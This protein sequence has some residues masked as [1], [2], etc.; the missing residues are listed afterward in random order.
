M[1][2]IEPRQSLVDDQEFTDHV[3]NDVQNACKKGNVERFETPQRIKIV[4]ETWSPETGLV[5][6]ALKLKRKAI[7]QKYK[8][9]IENLY[10]DPSQQNMKKSTTKKAS[11][12]RVR[13]TTDEDK[14]NDDKPKENENP[15]ETENAKQKK[16]SKGKREYKR[17]RESHGCCR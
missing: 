7:E 2:N 10:K 6:D 12:A 15:K 11:S 5:T 9:D 14:N 16:K 8:D 17:K 1:Q 4:T 3:L 13:P